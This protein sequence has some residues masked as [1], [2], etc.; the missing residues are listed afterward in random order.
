[1]PHLG[2]PSTGPFPT[3]EMRQSNDDALT[4]FKARQNVLISV[5]GKSAQHVFARKRW[6]AKTFGV[7]THVTV[8]RL[9]GSSSQS[10]P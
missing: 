6:Q 1:M 7:V 10:E 2:H 5:V 8:K 4:F 3:A 9:L